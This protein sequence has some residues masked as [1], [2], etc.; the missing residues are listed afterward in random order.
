MAISLK[1]KGCKRFIKLA[2]LNMEMLCKRCAN[3][4]KTNKANSEV[5]DAL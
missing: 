5:E 2:K 1:C 3:S 4:P